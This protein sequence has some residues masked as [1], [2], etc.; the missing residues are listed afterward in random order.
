VEGG[1]GDR[2]ISRGF[3]P[4]RSR[5]LAPCDFYLCGNLKDRVYRINPM[6]KKSERKTYEQ[7]FFIFLRKNFG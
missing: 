7:K 3:W 2:I 4:V 1:F 5:D 6:Q